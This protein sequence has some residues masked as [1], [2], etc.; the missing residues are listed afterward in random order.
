MIQ[1]AVTGVNAAVVGAILGAT[2][3]L[4]RESFVVD[5]VLDPLTV[6]LAAATF[7]LFNR[8]VDAVYLIFGG[9]GVGMAAFFLL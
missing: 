5:G 2:V 4:A 6:I 7:V 8:G 9:G 3:A 1:T